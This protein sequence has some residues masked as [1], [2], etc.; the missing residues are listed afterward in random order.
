MLGSPSRD[1]TSIQDEVNRLFDG[2]VTRGSLRNDGFAPAVDVEET[3]DEFV[4]RADLP[5]LSQKDVKVNLIGS[6]LTIRGERKQESERKGRNVHRVERS[7]GSFERTFSFDTPVKNQ[8]IQAHYR[9]GVL[10]VIVPKAE[11]AKAR[12]IEVQVS[13]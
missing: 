6:T 4:V 13:S 9:D 7:Y 12:E 11:E 10:E 2:F 3:A 5:G 8:G 1:V